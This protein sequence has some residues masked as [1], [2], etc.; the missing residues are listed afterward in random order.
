MRSSRQKPEVGT[1]HD[2]RRR[3][4]RVDVADD[5]GDLVSRTVGLRYQRATPD[6][7]AF[8]RDASS[9]MRLLSA[10]ERLELPAPGRFQSGASPIS[11][12]DLAVQ[13]RSK[14]RSVPQVCIP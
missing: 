6:T 4:V 2:P 5:A 10:S 9:I 3:P 1:D 7:E 13:R 11:F 14:P 12:A 8:S